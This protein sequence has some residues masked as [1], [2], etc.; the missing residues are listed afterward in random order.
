MP[1]AGYAYGV[2]EYPGMLLAID[3]G[4][5]TG[6]ACFEDAR[7]VACGLG[8]PPPAEVLDGDAQPFQDLIV[9]RPVV[10]RGTKQPEAIVKLA[11]KAGEWGGRYGV[12]GTQVRYVT[13]AEWKGQVDKGAHNMRVWLRLDDNEQKL[14]DHVFATSKGR[15]GLA[16][17]KRHNVFDAIGLGLFACGRMART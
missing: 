8:D 14:V 4:C 9:E 5:D 15:N 13:P 17:S 12:A 2:S 1:D 3:P 16:Q 7:L 6:W 11:V 10:Y